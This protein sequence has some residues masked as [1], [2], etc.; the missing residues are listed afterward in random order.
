MSSSHVA[1]SKLHSVSKGPV[2]SQ[3]RIPHWC[4]WE[5]EEGQHIIEKTRN[6]A[7]CRKVWKVYPCTAPA[8][9][10]GAV[11]LDTIILQ[12]LMFCRHHFNTSQIFVWCGNLHFNASLVPIFPNYYFLC[13]QFCVSLDILSEI[14]KILTIRECC[15]VLV[16]VK[17][18]LYLS[19][20]VFKT[21]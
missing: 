19:I 6:V 8:E 9:G 10:A 3:M 12:S 18:M 21:I 11:S 4:A 15:S 5:T 2:D 16:S 1:T 14:S 7:E 17:T 20:F 13:K